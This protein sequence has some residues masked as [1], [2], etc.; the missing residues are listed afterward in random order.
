MVAKAIDELRRLPEVDATAVQRVVAA[1]AA[2][3]LTPPG[4]EPANAT[5]T[6]R[7]L[8]GWG[9]FALCEAAAIV[10]F[11]F[12]GLGPH[13]SQPAATPLAS[14]SRPPAAAVGV[15][16]ASLDER[17]VVP[18]P[19]QFVFNNAKAHRVS[20]VGDFNA[21]DATR[22][23]MTHSKDG[24]LWSATIPILPG[25]HMY[26]FMVDDSVFVLDPS[27]PIARDPDLGARGSVVI[28][29]LQ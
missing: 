20:V 22:A 17:A 10:G 7:R 18:I 4:D 9:V 2:M 15:S 12:A 14:T 6:R 29:R 27:A 19:Q 23:P 11:W 1:A 25:R 5:P 13:R 26:G 16:A 3:R 24:E 21:W 8:N 28:V